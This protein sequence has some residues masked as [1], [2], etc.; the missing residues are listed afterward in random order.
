MIVSSFENSSLLLD[1]LESEIPDIVIADIDMPG[2]N[3]L[4]LC[5][6][7]CEKNPG[8]KVIMLTM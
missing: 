5:K 8:T 7:F 1:K 4:E 6:E 3:G 2:M